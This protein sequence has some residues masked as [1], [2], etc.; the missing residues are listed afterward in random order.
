[1][2]LLV[3]GTE[4]DLEVGD[5]LRL[6]T[7][8]RRAWQKLDVQASLGEK[9]LGQRKMQSCVAEVS[10]CVVRRR[11]EKTGRQ[12]EKSGRNMS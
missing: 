4:E 5:E 12:K 1:M 8:D 10:V 6:E 7:T 9:T 2:G 11:R 3:A